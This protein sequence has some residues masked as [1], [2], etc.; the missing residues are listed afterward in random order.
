MNFKKTVAFAGALTGLVLMLVA[1]PMIGEMIAT[2]APL[3]VNFPRKYSH[4]KHENVEFP[5]SD[6]LKLRGWFFPAADP[7]APAIVYAPATAKDQRQGLS[8]VAPLQKAGYQVLLFSY[9]G[10]GNSDGNRLK[11]SYGARESIDIDAA[12]R[13]LSETRGIA[14]IA[15]IGH[16]AGAVSIILS[17]ARNENIDAVIAAAPFTSLQDIWQDNRPQLVPSNLFQKIQYLFQ[18]RKGF[19]Q[20]QVRPIDVIGKISP[21]PVLLING[22]A[23]QRISP[24]RASRLFNAARFP[25][26]LIWLPD[27]G[28]A[29]VRSPGLDNLVPE[30]VQFLD[31]SLKHKTAGVYNRRCIQAL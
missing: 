21:R 18:I 16:S 29:A 10:S 11:F 25:K 23:D 22:T 12:V 5:T 13:Y 8:L 4:L 2:M 19:S 9:R 3:S 14:D 30:I 17:A 27:T 15:A 28:H 26:Q 20:S 6:G 31:E 1:S 7:S 24:E